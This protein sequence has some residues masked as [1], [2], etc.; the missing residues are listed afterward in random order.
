MPECQMTHVRN[1][2]FLWHS[3]AGLGN[4]SNMSIRPNKQAGPLYVGPLTELH[5]TLSHFP[6]SSLFQTPSHFH[7]CSECQHYTNIDIIRSS[8]YLALCPQCRN[9]ARESHAHDGH[10]ISGG[11]ILQCSSLLHLALHKYAHNR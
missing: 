3:P 7:T 10:G 11:F 6:P 2:N 4:R 1:S 5:C 8:L 9:R